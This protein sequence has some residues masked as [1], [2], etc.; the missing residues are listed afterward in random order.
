MDYSLSSDDIRKICPDVRIMTYPKVSGFSSLDQMFGNDNRPIALLYE[1]GPFYGHWVGL[2]KQGPKK[3][4]F[5]D[6]YGIPPDLE[7][8]FIK[9]G[10]RKESNQ[11]YPYLMDLILKSDG[12]ITTSI[13]QIQRDNPDI[14][15]C[16]RW[17]GLRC[18]ARKMPLKEFRDMFFG[19]GLSPD[20]LVTELTNKYWLRSN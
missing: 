7:L 17:V 13:K 12:K 8:K 3:Y 11:D 15:T 18:L 2:M 20:R 5:F 1:T 14:A 4:E 10:Y 16:G 9:Q 19:K 6:P